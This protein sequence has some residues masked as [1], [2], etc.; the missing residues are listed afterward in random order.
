MAPSIVTQG[1]DEAGVQAYHRACGLPDGD[2]QAFVL[3]LAALTLPAFITTARAVTPPEA[4]AAGLHVGHAITLA[5]PLAIG[6]A[7]TTRIGPPS[8]RGPHGELVTVAATTEDEGGNVTAQQSA[9]FYFR[10]PA[11]APQ[12]PAHPSQPPPS[13]ITTRF[14]AGTAQAYASAAGD[15]IAIHTD[16]AAARAAGLSRPIAQGLCTLAFVAAA[17][18]Q[19]RSIPPR[20]LTSVRARFTD[21]VYWDDTLHTQLTE[22]NAAGVGFTSHTT[23]GRRVLDHGHL[24]WDAHPTK[25]QA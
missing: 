12:P 1:L 17:A 15:T 14:P 3:Y 13:G 11:P 5:R 19:A 2:N 9:T 8:Q 25:E 18:A 23:D 7:L 22:E 4:H 20:Q 24:E 10:D 16:P 6:S 21:V